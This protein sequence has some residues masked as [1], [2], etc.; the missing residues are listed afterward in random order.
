MLIIITSILY[1]FPAPYFHVSM[2]IAGGQDVES[3][4]IMG[5]VLPWSR[6]NRFILESICHL[7]TAHENEG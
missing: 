4:V 5:L 6:E 1:R 7:I 3:V 2:V